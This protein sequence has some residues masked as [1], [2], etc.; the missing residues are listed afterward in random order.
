MERT[1]LEFLAVAVVVALAACTHVQGGP[2]AASAPPVPNVSTTTP[3]RFGPPT[4]SA[5][6]V[7]VDEFN[8][9]LLTYVRPRIEESDLPLG[10]GDL[11]EISVFDAPELSG[12]KLRIPLAGSVTLPLIGDI[13]SAGLTPAALQRVTV[14]WLPIL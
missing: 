13:L 14:R 4:G 9:R 5:S 10:A 3:P 1:R 2:T 8:R 7:E 12:L 6:K 11:V